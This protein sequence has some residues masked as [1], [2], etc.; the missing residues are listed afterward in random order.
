[1]GQRN[2]SRDGSSAV[3]EIDLLT[4]RGD[5][6]I[7]SAELIEQPYSGQYTEKIYD[8]KSPW[9]SSEWT[10]IKF[11]DE[12][13][14]WCGEFRVMYRGVSVSKNFGVIIV[15]TSDYIYELDINTAELI[16]YDSQL[17]FIDITTSTK[18]DIFLTD[19]YDIKF[20]V[21]N[22]MG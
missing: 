16:G 12:N 9:N 10:W 1:M 4:I 18:G 2:N 6:M 11:V 13:G 3:E 21:K 20:L 5:K 17:D 7:C 22:E 15:L 19:G 8:I 14:E